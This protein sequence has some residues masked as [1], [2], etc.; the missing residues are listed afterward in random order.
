MI[1]IPNRQTKKVTQTNRSKILGDLWASFNLDL[2]S[3]LGLI[4][5]SPR[6]K[7]NTGS[8]S[9]QGL[10]VAFEAFDVNVWTI[11]GTRVFKSSAHNLIS[12]FTEDASTGAL[13]DYDP[14]YSDLGTFNAVLMSSS[15]TKI[16]SKAE[17]GAGA[18]AWT[19]R[20]SLVSPTSN[21]KLCYF[22]KFNRLYFIDEFTKIKS[23]DTS[24][25]TATSGSYFFSHPSYKLGLIYTIEASDTDIWIG[26]IVATLPGSNSSFA[27]ASI[28]RWDGITSSSITAEYKVKAKGVLALCRDDR[29]IMHAIDSRG[30][31]LAFNGSGFEEIARLP[32]NRDYLAN[33]ITSNYNS[34]IHPNGFKF[35]RNGTFIVLVNNL[36][37][38]SGGT[39]KEN[40]SSGIWE[41][42][43]DTGFVHR[44]SLSYTPM[45]G[46]VIT[47]H[48]QNRVSAIG[49]LYE[50]DIYSASASGK[51]TIICGANYFT[52]ATTVASGIF[53]DDPLDTTQKYGY[54]V[55]SWIQ[56]QNLKD[57]WQKLAL[58]YRKLLDSGDKIIVKYRTTEVAATDISIT[59]VNTTSFTTTTNVLGKEGYEVEITQGTGSGKCSHITLISNNAGTYTVTVDETYTGV[60]TGT[61][62]VRV[63]A[64][65]KC[66]TIA[67]QTTES[68]MTA[69][70]KTSERIQVKCCLQFTGENELH[71]LA[72]IN[73]EHTPL[74]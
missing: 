15:T 38:D 28:L 19:A 46:S 59:W 22:S 5:V 34:F 45:A 57:T 37:G 8:V 36:V 12:A 51:P 60:T 66:L 33:A 40:L 16:L 42:H 4:K 27:Q 58:K 68:N 63:Q 52:D 6:L 64:W 17:D 55:T 71:E 50:A 25:S 32:L 47:D 70:G 26:T 24:Y 14:I 44:Q 30:A 43:K 48:G 18:G 9:N 2:Q 29:G 72:I 53:I 67:D 11:A 49:A 20:Y 21:H 3:D 73:K 74:G 31:L 23:M 56:S 54:F 69:L 62:K 65:V 7:L 13:T 10:S 39:I 35:T 41:Y 1:T 61:A